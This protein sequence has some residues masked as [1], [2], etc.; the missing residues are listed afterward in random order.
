MECSQRD[1]M[2]IRNA[3][4]HF[5]LRL[6][7]VVMWRGRAAMFNLRCHW[8]TC[9]VA[10]GGQRVTKDPER[11]CILTDFAF[12]LSFALLCL[13]KALFWLLNWSL[14]L[15][16]VALE[17]LYIFRLV[18]YTLTDFANKLLNIVFSTGCQVRKVIYIYNWTEQGCWLEATN[19]HWPFLKTIIRPQQ[20]RAV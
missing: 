9:Q 8:I 2:L 1:M 17:T 11:P 14:I 19:Q 13:T 6:R 5:N 7:L 10:T 12:P 15:F 3:F 18:L 16:H 20:S 4:T